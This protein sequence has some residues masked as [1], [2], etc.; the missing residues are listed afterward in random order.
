MADEVVT[1]APAVP[2]PAPAKTDTPAVKGKSDALDA[3]REVLQPVTEKQKRAE[4]LA[5]AEAKGAN[6]VLKGLGVKKSERARML[7]EIKTGKV[8]IAEAKK[9]AEDATAKAQAATAE[10]DAIKP[11]R[12]ALK[13]FADATFAE[14]PESAQRFIAAQKV[15]DPIA[16]MQLIKTMRE[17]G[18]LSAAQAKDAATK[19]ESKGASTT[20][21]APNPVPPKSGPTL[22]YYEQWQALKAAG[23]K[24]G[25]AAFRRQY[26]VKIDEQTPTK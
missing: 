10:L 13:E 5:K 3:L 9:Q 26:G 7:E 11:Y 19:P 22:N 14:L 15:E 8:T 20:I 24:L 12:D 23:D 16:R 25:A 1:T 17:T 18:M 6:E 2:V 4:R 21:A